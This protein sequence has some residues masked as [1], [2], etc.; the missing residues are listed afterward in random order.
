MP[1]SRRVHFLDPV[2]NSVILPVPLTPPVVPH[3]PRTPSPTYSPGSSLSSPSP[4]TPPSTIYYPFLTPTTLNAIRAHP[5]I[6][7]NNSIPHLSFDV[8]MPPSVLSTPS[9]SLSGNQRVGVPSHINQP[10]LATI[11][12]DPAVLNDPATYPPLPSITLVSDLLPWSIHVEAS[13]TYPVPVVTI[14]DVLQT[15][16]I[17]LRIPIV[18]C[19]W[20][21]LPSPTQLLISVAFYR[22][23]DGIT[24]YNTRESQRRKGVRRID[25]LTGRTRL[26]GLTPV[27]DK[28][29][30]FVVGWGSM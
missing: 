21:C 11:G 4:S 22:R 15:L 13:Q 18:P 12:F 1:T 28:P 27:V 17:T 16:Y 9:S 8:S 26:L 25:F 5:V 3:V 6:A 7:Y 30:L 20:T 24:D 23:L 19:E 2:T 10:N 14:F 29:G